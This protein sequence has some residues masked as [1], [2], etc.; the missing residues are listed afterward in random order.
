MK[1]K[2][3]LPPSPPTATKTVRNDFIYGYG[4][5]T[6]EA[7]VP[8]SQ[9]ELLIPPTKSNSKAAEAEREIK[10]IL[11]LAREG[12]TASQ[13]SEISG[14]NRNR[15]VQ[16]VRRFAEYGAKLA[17]EPKRKKRQID[18]RK[19]TMWTDEMEEQLIALHHEGLTF[20]Q[21]AKEI[22]VSKGAISSKVRSLVEAE[23]LKPRMQEIMWTKEEMDKMF[24][25]RAQG[26]TWG[27]IADRL[28]RKITACHNA[29]GRERERREKCQKK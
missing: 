8:S 18:K 21:I 7:S 10:V 4:K 6:Y 11:D 14:Y 22:G 26:K 25:M 9:I 5:N 2:R 28:G 29:Y 24:Q 23:V 16:V 15:V 13:I 1:I 19:L 27:E 17:P 20:A 12:K 3:H